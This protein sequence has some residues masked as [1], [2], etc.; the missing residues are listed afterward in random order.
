MLHVGRPKK[1]KIRQITG[2]TL[3][4]DEKVNRR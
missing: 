4:V 3:G 2:E 1:S